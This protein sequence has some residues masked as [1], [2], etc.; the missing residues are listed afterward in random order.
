MLNITIVVSVFIIISAAVLVTAN[1]FRIAYLNNMDKATKEPKSSDEKPPLENDDKE[2]SKDKED[3]NDKEDSKDNKD[4]KTAETKTDGL[5]LAKC[6]NGAAIKN[7]VK[8]S[9]VFLP[10]AACVF[11]LYSVF[12]P[13][14][15]EREPLT[16][17]AVL[18]QLVL[19]EVVFVISPI[20]I[21]VKKIP[22][23]LVLLAIYIKIAGIAAGLIIAPDEWVTVLVRP[24][25]GFLVGGIITLT[26]LLLS[27]GRVGAGDMKLYAAVGLY[28]GMMGVIEIMIYSMFFA[29]VTGL[30]MIAFK[31]AQ[32]KSAMPMAPFICL[33]IG[34]YLIFMYL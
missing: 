8:S 17:L 11:L 16:V 27:R 33:S 32:M 10:I 30:V 1:T 23:Q 29:A 5:T 7:M 14:V 28:F 18:Q 12:L 22:N 15:I 31:K 4:K 26:C 9:K 20:D 3:S 24:L 2:N 34:I 13:S 25:I 6:L 21:A 19:F